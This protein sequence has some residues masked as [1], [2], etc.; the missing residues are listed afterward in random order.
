MQNVREQL[1]KIV[2]AATMD[3]NVAELLLLN[4]VEWLGKLNYIEFLRGVVNTSPSTGCYR[5]RAL[6]NALNAIKVYR[7]LIQLPPPPEL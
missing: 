7:S 3:T 1:L 6:S 5:Q 2:H 4:N